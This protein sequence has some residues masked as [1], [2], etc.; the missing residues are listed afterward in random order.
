M[1]R[2]VAEPDSANRIVQATAYD[3]VNDEIY[4]IGGNPA[5]D[6]ATYVNL[7]QQYNP[8]TGAWT[9]KAG[10]PTP[11]GWITASYAKGKI[12]VI[13]GND[14]ANGADANNEAYDI[15]GD[16]WSTLAPRPRPDGRLGGHM[17]RLAGF[18]NG[19]HRPDQRLYQRGHL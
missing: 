12:Y 3:P 17:E 8:A 1:W 15:S 16:S 2:A 18:R 14:N 11:R 13:G 5:G 4:M 10:M 19:R 6:S 7:C 9:D